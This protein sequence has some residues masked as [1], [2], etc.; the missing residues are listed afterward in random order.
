MYFYGVYIK[1]KNKLTRVYEIVDVEFKRK[2]IIARTYNK[3]I[4]KFGVDLQT[5]PCELQP[6]Q[7]KGCNWF[8][9]YKITKINNSF[10]KDAYVVYGNELDYRG[11]ETFEE[12]NVFFWYDSDQE[13]ATVHDAEFFWKYVKGFT[14]IDQGTIHSV[15]P[16]MFV[17]QTNKPAPNPQAWEMT[18][19]FSISRLRRI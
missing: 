9:F 12:R 7:V 16:Y 15:S 13:A 3:N 4:N 2:E 14:D 6:I 19:E 5:L 17:W 1:Q 10:V 18:M 8:K 11:E